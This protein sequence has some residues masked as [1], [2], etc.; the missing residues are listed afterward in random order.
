MR[1]CGGACLRPH[2]EAA[3]EAHCVRSPEE[4]IVPSCQETQRLSLC[5]LDR[6]KDEA[7]RVALSCR[8]GHD[9][10]R[11]RDLAWTSSGDRFE[12]SVL[13]EKLRQDLRAL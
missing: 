10:Y 1:A 7:Q 9:T 12:L 3:P 5:R 13:V 4:A 8:I 2:R 6:T 11:G